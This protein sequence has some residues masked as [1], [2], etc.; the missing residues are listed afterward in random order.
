MPRLLRGPKAIDSR[1][2]HAGAVQSP[3]TGHL[4]LGIGHRLTVRVL[5]GLEHGIDAFSGHKKRFFE[6]EDQGRI[7]P[8]VHDD[9]HLFAERSIAVN[10]VRLRRHIAAGQVLVQQIE[11]NGFAGITFVGGVGERFAGAA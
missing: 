2:R 9:I 3:H 8:V 5:F 6:A 11:P 7:L 4:F 10:H 1:D